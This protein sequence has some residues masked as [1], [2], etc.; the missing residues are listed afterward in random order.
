M[1]G[2][3]VSNGGIRCVELNE[4]GGNEWGGYEGAEAFGR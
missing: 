3:R 2:D 4:E 1:T